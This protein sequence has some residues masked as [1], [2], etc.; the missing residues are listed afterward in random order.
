MCTE[1]PQSVAPCKAR[2]S[3]TLQGFHQNPGPNQAKATLRV[4]ALPGHLQITSSLENLVPRC[5][6]SL[7]CNQGVTAWQSSHGSSASLPGRTFP[8]TAP[9]RPGPRCSKPGRRRTLGPGATLEV[10]FLLKQSVS[11]LQPIV[12]MEMGHSGMFAGNQL[13]LATWEADRGGIY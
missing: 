12:A 9:A 13:E 6:L 8:A 3:W 1:Q 4:L 5:L 2:L 7:A 11:V 10:R